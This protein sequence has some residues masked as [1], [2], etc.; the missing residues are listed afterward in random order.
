[1]TA[2]FSMHSVSHRGVHGMQCAASLLGQTRMLVQGWPVKV[3]CRCCGLTSVPGKNHDLGHL[4]PTYPPP[5]PW[6]LRPSQPSPCSTAACK[7]H[8][9]SAEH[10]FGD[11]CTETD[12][13][14]TARSRHTSPTQPV[15]GSCQRLSPLVEQLQWRS[16]RLA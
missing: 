11:D 4:R 15:L 13:C 3:N 14:T 2:T 1:M 9:Q 10:G 6:Q 12:L 8:M 7:Q 5:P 16:L